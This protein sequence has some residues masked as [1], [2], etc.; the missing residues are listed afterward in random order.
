MPGWPQSLPRVLGGPGSEIAAICN[1][2]INM[3]SNRIEASNLLKARMV[4]L[5]SSG[6]TLASDYRQP[7]RTLDAII[8]HAE[9]LDSVR[10]A[11]LSA[12]DWVVVTTA[13]STYAIHVLGDGQYSVTGG[14]F[15]KKGMSPAK[16]T[17][18]GCTWG[19]SAIKL[20]IVAAC[21]LRLEFGNR[22]LT[23]G[24]R[25]VQVFRGAGRYTH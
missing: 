1:F 15:D 18:N 19:G 24:I 14:W 6:A 8:R 11:E 12:G 20:D 25:R 16:I 21:G 7:V 2:E 5:E 17:I 23:S 22:V 10:K 3:E 9:G 13:N 4:M